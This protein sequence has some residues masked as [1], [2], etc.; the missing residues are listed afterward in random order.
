METKRVS[1][2]VIHVH[3]SVVENR[4]LWTDSV[5]V[6]FASMVVAQVI[7]T[8]TLDKHIE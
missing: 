3:S 7:A 8:H 2:A 5:K 4:V 1:T 6:S